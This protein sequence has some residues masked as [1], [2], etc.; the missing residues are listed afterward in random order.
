M[1]TRHAAY[2]VILDEDIRDDDAEESVLPALRMIKF[3]ASV[4][5]VPASYE[6]AIAR[7]RRDRSW[8]EALLKLA[9]DGPGD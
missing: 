1:T 9:H 8:Q 7:S 3:V 4:E 6:H 2:I 5:P